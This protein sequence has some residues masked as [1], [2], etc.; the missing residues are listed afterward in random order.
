M[1]SE[2]PPEFIVKI[3]YDRC[4]RCKRCVMNCSFGCMHFTDRVV[5]E[6]KLC[7]A[8]QRCVTFCPEHAI[9]ITKNEMAYKE[10]LN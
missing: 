2:L 5:P 6:H 9:T 10:N 8:C 3:D 4:R 1:A 7:V